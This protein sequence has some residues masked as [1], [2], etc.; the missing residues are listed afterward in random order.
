MVDAGVQARPADAGATEPS[1]RRSKRARQ[2]REGVFTLRDARSL[3]GSSRYRPGKVVGHSPGSP[4]LACR[5]LTC[6][7]RLIEID[8]EERGVC[9]AC[10]DR[11]QKLQLLVPE[12]PRNATSAL[13]RD[14]APRWAAFSPSGTFLHYCRLFDTEDARRHANAPVFAASP[15]W[16]EGD[17]MRWIGCEHVV[18]KFPLVDAGAWSGSSPEAAG[19][20]LRGMDFDER[21]EAGQTRRPLK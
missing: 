3:V 18:G 4:P 13:E 14:T 9:F 2:E 16:H 21:K 11:E 17:L 5:V 12:R 10:F 15:A 7:G 19:V 20:L 1:P 6:D 8:S